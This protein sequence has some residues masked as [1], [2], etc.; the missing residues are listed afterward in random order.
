MPV[1]VEALEL[2]VEAH[3]GVHRS[4]CGPC[5]WACLVGVAAWS[6]TR[7]V[8][9]Q[10]ASWAAAV[11]PAAGSVAARPCG[12]PEPSSGWG[13]RLAPWDVELRHGGLL[14]GSVGVDLADR[15]QRQAQVADLGEQA[16]EGRLVSDRAGDGGHA[17]VVAADLQAFKPG[18]P[19]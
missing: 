3:R 19:A 10:P 12:C 8:R 17:V 5:A 2:L 6:P 1:V 15:E 7:S 16:V 9:Q 13:S 11:D 18:R 4:P 14:S